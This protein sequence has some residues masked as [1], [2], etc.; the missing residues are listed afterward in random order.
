MFICVHLWLNSLRTDTRL[1]GESLDVAREF[2]GLPSH[3][4]AV[5]AD[6]LRHLARPHQPPQRADAD[7]EAIRDLL[8]IRP[9]SRIDFQVTADKTLTARVQTRGSEGLFG[10]LHRPGQRTVTIEEMDDA[11]AAEVAERSAP[12]R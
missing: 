12:K 11:I 5:V 1:A 10:L 2:G 7:R 9:G 3:Q 4:L 6:R 8:S